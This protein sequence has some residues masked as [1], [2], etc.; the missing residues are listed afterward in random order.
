M[1]NQKDNSLLYVAGF[2]ALILLLRKKET[3]KKIV[4]YKQLSVLTKGI[5]Q[6]NGQEKIYS[7]TVW[8]DKPIIGEYLSR[9][10]SIIKANVEVYADAD[11]VQNFSEFAQING[12]QNTLPLVR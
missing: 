4:E 3:T 6:S 2:V 1:A 8:S 10:G 9:N 12:V 5:F 7:L 11:K